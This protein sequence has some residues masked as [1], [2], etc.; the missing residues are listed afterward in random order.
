MGVSELWWRLGLPKYF[1][2]RRLGVSERFEW[3]WMGLAKPWWKWMGKQQIDGIKWM[4]IQSAEWH[5]V[6][7]KPDTEQ[8]VWNED[9]V[10]DT[11]EAGVGA[12]V[13]NC[14]DEL[15]PIDCPGS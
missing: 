1:E 14:R 6:E 2:W 12:T 3:K 7:R 4:G 13:H 9:R 15:Q 11:A 8:G 5:R 10:P